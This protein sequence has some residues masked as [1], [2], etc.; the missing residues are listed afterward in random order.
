MSGQPKGKSATRSAVNRATGNRNKHLLAAERRR[1]DEADGR[2]NKQ[3]PVSPQKMNSINKSDA[4]A[5]NAGFDKLNN[6]LV[7]MD[8]VLYD[9]MKKL[10]G[11]EEMK[12]WD[13]CYDARTESEHNKLHRYMTYDQERK[14]YR[15]TNGILLDTKERHLEYYHSLKNNA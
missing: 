8:G 12:I 11:D 7:K 13:A 2:L 6:R 14:M 1:T 3:N 5:K 4:R 15:T 9:I 10:T